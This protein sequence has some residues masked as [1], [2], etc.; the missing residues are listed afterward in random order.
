MLATLSEG[1]FLPKETQAEL[2]AAGIDI[3]RLGDQTLTLSERMTPLKAIM[4]DSALVTKLFG[5]ENQNAALALI[6]GISQMDQYNLAIQ[7]TNTAQDQ[8]NIVMETQA[9]KTARLKAKVD[10][11]KLGMFNL[12]GAAGP[13]L[14]VLTDTMDGATKFAP[15][16]MALG[17][18]V[19]FLTDAEKMKALWDGIVS[20]STGVWTGAQWLLN[21]AFYASPL[22]WIA[23]AVGA[24]VGVVVLAWNKFEGFRAVILT[25]WDTIKGFGNVLK[26]FVIDRIKGIISGIGAM[27]SAIYKLFTGDFS[28]AWDAA[29]QGTKDLSG[30][31]AIKNAIDSSINVV[32]GIKEN[33]DTNLAAQAKTEAAVPP[34]PKAPGIVPP[35]VP[36][37]AGGKVPVNKAPAKA[38]SDAISAGGSRSTSVNITFR[39]MVEKIVFDGTVKDNRGDLEK[40]ITQIMMRVLGAAQ[41]TS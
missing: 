6:S 1:R 36:G 16:L 14:T 27:G 23:L 25:I 10:D 13:Y 29:V 38:S 35:T 17:T 3:N 22:G 8:A 30:Y 20:I 31:T 37:A 33:F 34:V 9:E 32:G 41:A 39:N 40:Q 21:A 2:K 4:G 7:G 5:K 24:V 12:T 15:I 19:T 28:G 26:D 11:L 18:A